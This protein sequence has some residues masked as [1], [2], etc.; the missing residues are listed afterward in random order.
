M[1][2]DYDWETVGYRLIPE[3][4]AYVMSAELDVWSLS[5]KVRCKGGRTRQ[6]KARQL[7]PDDGRVRLSQDGK[8]GRFHV[9][10]HLYPQVFP[11]LVAKELQAARRHPQ[12][13]CRQGHPL[14]EF[15]HEILKMWMT[16]KP[17]IWYWGTGNR[18]C[19][20]CDDDAPEGFPDDNAFSLHYGV[21]SM[22]EYSDAP[23]E[24]KLRAEDFSELD[25]EDAGF[26]ISDR[27]LYNADPFPQVD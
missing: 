5:R 21:A 16:P 19:L 6:T 24:P 27:P 26:I 20:W 13:E 15:E 14:L 1:T 2:T 18:I 3:W 23:A 7:I 10:R 8:T 22:P 25:W 12:T 17:R 4:S 11:D 9:R